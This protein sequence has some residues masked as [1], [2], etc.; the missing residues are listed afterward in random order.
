MAEVIKQCETAVCRFV[1]G[2]RVQMARRFLGGRYGPLYD[3][4]RECSSGCKGGVEAPKVRF[5]G[6]AVYGEN[7]Q[8][9]SP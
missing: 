3:V 7:N 5:I 8:K 2:R 4:G 9:L 6:A 1:D